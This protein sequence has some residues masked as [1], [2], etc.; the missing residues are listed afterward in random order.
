M[1]TSINFQPVTPAQA[2]VQEC[3]KLMDSCF[4]RNDIFRGSLNCLTFKRQG[5]EYENKK[6]EEKSRR[7]SEKRD[8]T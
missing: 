4:R 1:G 8:L 2:G 3:Q 7:D 6:I 5:G